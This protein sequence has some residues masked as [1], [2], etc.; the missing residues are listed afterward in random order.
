MYQIFILTDDRVLREELRSWALDC[1]T[2]RGLFPQLETPEDLEAAYYRIRTLQPDLAV[3]A[4]LGV[5][6]LNAAE[7]LRALCPDCALVWCSDLDFSLQ[8]YRLNANYFILGPPTMEE[9]S[10]GLSR[11]LGMREVNR[12]GRIL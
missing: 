9:L 7:H 11:W 6:G 4:L 12:D 1:L 5:A 10:T 8:A 3:V 2:R